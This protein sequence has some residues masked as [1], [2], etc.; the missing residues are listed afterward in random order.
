MQIYFY[1]TFM[2]GDT[3]LFGMK[4]KK[5]LLMGKLPN[6]FNHSISY[7]SFFFEDEIERDSR[8]DTLNHKE[9]KLKI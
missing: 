9:N 4:P 2:M 5:L 6:P 7:F 1:D 8:E 3:F